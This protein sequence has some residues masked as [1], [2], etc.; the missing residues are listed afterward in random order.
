LGRRTLAEEVVQETLLAVL[1]GIDRFEERSSLKT[2][3]FRIL[4]N[5]AR[6]RAVREARTLPF[7]SLEFDDEP[8]VPEERF[9][10]GTAWPGHWA[11]PPRPLAE[12]PEERLLSAE[13]RRRLA[14]ALET[15]PEPQRIVVVLRDVL[16]EA[17]RCARAVCGGGVMT[18]PNKAELTCREIVDLVTN[19]L[20]G[21]LEPSERLDFERHLVWCSWCRD[22]L[23][24]MRTTIEVTGEPDLREPPS[25]LRE[26]LIEGFRD[27]KR[28]RG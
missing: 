15:L 28:S 13:L 4:V 9:Q 10:S 12:V 25:P 14:E 7:S 1:E 18:G 11:K 5:K 23:D 17:A 6:T 26:Q 22:Y 27:W 3:I 2:W 16:G 24:Q 8:P 19:Y 20:E 21:A